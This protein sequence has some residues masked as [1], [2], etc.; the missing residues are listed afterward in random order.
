[1]AC[2]SFLA[3]LTTKSR[4]AG[5]ASSRTKWRPAL[6]STNPSGRRSSFRKSTTAG[7][8]QLVACVVPRSKDYSALELRELLIRH[9]T[10]RL[11]AYMVPSK[12]PTFAASSRS[13]LMESLISLR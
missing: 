2:L 10:E 12:V 13:N 4:S 6:R 8:A 9:A 5:T 3:A 11:P 7:A 1:M